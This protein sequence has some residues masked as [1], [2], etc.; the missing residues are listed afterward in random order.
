MFSTHHH[1]GAYCSFLNTL[2]FQCLKG[3]N[4]FSIKYLIRAAIGNNKLSDNKQ[5]LQEVGTT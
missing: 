1:I 4:Y 5:R 3:N 2:I